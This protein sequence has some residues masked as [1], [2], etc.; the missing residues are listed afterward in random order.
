MRD[1]KIRWS[2]D[3]WN[4]M[5]G[6]TKVSPGCDH[7]YAETIALK[8]R[9]NAFPNGFDPTFKPGKLRQPKTL[10]RSKGARR[11][12]VNSMSDVHHESFTWDQIAA[13]YDAMLE[14]PEHDYLVLTKRPER[15]AR[16]LLGQHAERNGRTAPPVAH[17]GAP[18]SPAE[19]DERNGYLM[20]R[21]VGELTLGSTSPRYGLPSHIWLGTSIESDRY[22]FRADWLRVIPAMVRFISAEPL[23]GP[24]PS[25]DL[26]G[27]GW[28]I[29]GGESGPGYRPMDHDWARDLRDRCDTAGVSYYFKQS[30]APRT[31]MGIELDGRLHEE[32]PFPHPG[33]GEPRV[34]GRY[35]DTP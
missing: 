21:M 26:S 32:Y 20:A 23:L 12:F 2:D 29:A 14:T 11:I 6:C 31:E 19:A 25:L 30:A 22:T 15:M 10:L 27:L 18:G 16:F 34:L 8:F 5:T 35:V 7:C 13:V 1:T 17:L 3:T 24:V 9:G 28:V 33:T 4:P